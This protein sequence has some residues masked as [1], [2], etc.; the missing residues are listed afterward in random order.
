MKRRNPRKRPRIAPVLANGNGLKYGKSGIG[1]SVSFLNYFSLRRL[2]CFIKY[3]FLM[4]SIISSLNIF[5]IFYFGNLYKL[6]T[7]EVGLTEFFMF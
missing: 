2:L 7:S 6:T 3:W 5:S 1:K 4:C